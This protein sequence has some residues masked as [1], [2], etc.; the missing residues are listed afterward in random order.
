MIFFG[1]TSSS[2]LSLSW[3]R[4]LAILPLAAATLGAQANR[5]DLILHNGRIAP[6]DDANRLATALVVRDGRI[7]ERTRQ[8]K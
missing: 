7:V 8:E 4:S 3:A 2:L 1:F 5:A 6:L